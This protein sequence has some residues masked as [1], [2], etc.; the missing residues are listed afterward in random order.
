ME[1]LNAF[2]VKNPD[3]SA[4]IIQKGITQFKAKNTAE[5]LKTFASVPKK[6]A[7]DS[8]NITRPKPCSLLAVTMKPLSTCVLL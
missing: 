5:A 4:V 1:T 6:D 3:N 7:P 2:L 8:S